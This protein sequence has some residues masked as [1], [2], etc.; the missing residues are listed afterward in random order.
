MVKIV[1]MCVYDIWCVM[2]D[3]LVMDDCEMLEDLIVVV[4]NDVMCCGEV[5]S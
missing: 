2:I 1:M 3:L 4:V 5:F